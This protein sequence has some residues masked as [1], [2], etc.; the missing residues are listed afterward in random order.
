MKME[1]GCLSD[2]QKV[3]LIRRSVSKGYYTSE[4]GTCVTLGVFTSGED[5]Q[6]IVLLKK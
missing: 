5:A 6:G 3:H 2:P 4:T 1:A